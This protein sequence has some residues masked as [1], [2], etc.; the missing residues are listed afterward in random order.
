MKHT[1]GEQLENN[2]TIFSNLKKVG[3]PDFFYTRLRAR[4]E[5]ELKSN[6]MEFSTKPILII[7]ALT[8]FLFVNSLLVQ[9]DTNLVKPNPNQNMEAL[10]ASY[11]QAVTN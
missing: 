7:C 11:D 9:K 5:N 6:G 4:M 3:A 2:L 8:L 1:T 10:A